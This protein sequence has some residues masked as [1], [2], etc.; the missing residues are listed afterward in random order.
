M[1]QPLTIDT[2]PD[3]EAQQIALFRQRLPLLPGAERPVKLASP[4]DVVL[5]KLVWY[6][7]DNRVSDQQWRDVQAI[8]RV[9]ATALDLAYLRRWAAELRIND[10]LDAALRG[11]RPLSPPNDPQQQRMF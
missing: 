5:N 6:E 9:Q 4:E 3:A 1:P 10:L 2:A 11:E 8:I 7:R